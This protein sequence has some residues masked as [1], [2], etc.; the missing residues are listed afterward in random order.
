[1]IA[2]AL[3]AIDNADT[4]ALV[5]YHGKDFSLEFLSDRHP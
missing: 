2:H 5:T 3:Q 1:M 4:D